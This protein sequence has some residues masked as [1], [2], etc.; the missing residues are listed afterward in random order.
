MVNWQLSKEWLQIE[1]WYKSQLI[2]LNDLLYLRNSKSAGNF[3]YLDIPFI[4]SAPKNQY[5]FCSYTHNPFFAFLLKEQ[6]Q[7]LMGYFY[8]LHCFL[9]V[10]CLLVYFL[11]GHRAHIFSL[12]YFCDFRI[13]TAYI[14][15]LRRYQRE[16]CSD[17]HFS[18]FNFL[19]YYI[20]SLPKLK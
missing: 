4:P 14:F 1:F 13:F 3:L 8:L 6:Q 2:G 20:F 12:E 17:T 16:D 11:V 7:R 5:T 9:S 19:S 10:R 18:L 15:F